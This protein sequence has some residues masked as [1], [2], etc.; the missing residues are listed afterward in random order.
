[1]YRVGIVTF[2]EENLND[3]QW[4]NEW[5]VGVIDTQ[6]PLEKNT[7]DLLL[8]YEQSM[9]QIAKICEY[10][11]H[12]RKVTNALLWVWT[13]LES[14]S[15]RKVYRSLG[16]DG[17]VTDQLTVEEWLLTLTNHL[18]RFK[19][20]GTPREEEL[21]VKAPAGEILLNGRNSTVK[22]GDQKAIRLTRLEY[23]VLD[24][25][26]RNA[27]QVVTYEEIW[28]EIWQQDGEESNLYRVSNIIFHLR[29]KIEQDIK[30]PKVIKTVRSRGYWLDRV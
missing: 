21:F 6:E 23:Q 7:Y 14:E 16:V 24:L 28:E 30:Q 25:L 2:G 10:I 19:T 8:F 26:Y 13:T 1:M 3:V 27:G 5:Q 9:E 11:L 15:T 4:P 18:N 22:I 17:V 29:S 20:K 12:T